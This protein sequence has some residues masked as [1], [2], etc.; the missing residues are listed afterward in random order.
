MGNKQRTLLSEE[1]VLA[2]LAE[3]RE[4][5]CTPDFRHTEIRDCDFISVDFRSA[6]FTGAKIVRTDF[7]YCDLRFSQFRK[8]K[9]RKVGFHRSNMRECSFQPKPATDCSYYQSDFAGAIVLPAYINST[10]IDGWLTV[11]YAGAAISLIPTSEGWRVAT[12]YRRLCGVDEFFN[13]EAEALAEDT[14]MP[15][16]RRALLTRRLYTLEQLFNAHMEKENVHVMGLK[17]NREKERENTKET[18]E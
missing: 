13:K 18:V 15:H 17:A 4:K 6:D 16:T 9:L 3:A 1:E 7:S 12:L 8:T 2:R 11:S 14:T 10:D 5:G